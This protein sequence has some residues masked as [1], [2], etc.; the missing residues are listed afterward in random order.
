MSAM[1]FIVNPVKPRVG[2]GAAGAIFSDIPV[3]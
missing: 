2:F 3:V 1:A